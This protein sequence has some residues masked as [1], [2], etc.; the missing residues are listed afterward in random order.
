MNKELEMIPYIGTKE[1]LAIPMTKA[2]YYEY[3]GWELPVGENGASAGMLVE[4]I[5]SSKPNHKAHKGYISWSPL[6]VFLDAYKRS[7]TW[8]DELIIEHEELTNKII[9][10]R[11]AL[12][13]NNIQKDQYV[14]LAKQLVIMDTYCAIL[15]ERISKL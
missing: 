10:L 12:D 14:I 11:N 13:V 7:L 8:Q 3:I 2:A 9:K 4:Y 5:N 15:S 6:G 1:I